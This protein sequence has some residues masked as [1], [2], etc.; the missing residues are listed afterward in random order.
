MY[1]LPPHQN[2]SWMLRTKTDFEEMCLIHRKPKD[3]VFSDILNNTQTN[4][5]YSPNQI[6]GSHLDE[7]LSEALNRCKY[8]RSF[9]LRCDTGDTHDIDALIM[10]SNEDIIANEDKNIGFDLSKDNLQRVNSTCLFG[11]KEP[12][13]RTKRIPIAM[14]NAKALFNDCKTNMTITDCMQ[15]DTRKKLSTIYDN[16]QTI[17]HQAQSG[18]D[19]KIICQLVSQLTKYFRILLGI[20]EENPMLLTLLQLTKK[21]CQYLNIIANKVRLIVNSAFKFFKFLAF[22]IKTRWRSEISEVSLSSGS[23]CLR[24]LANPIMKARKWTS[25]HFGSPDWISNFFMKSISSDISNVDIQTH[26]GGNPIVRRIFQ[27]LF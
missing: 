8:V 15:P 27:I 23:K 21:F 25:N 11:E 24:Y 5:V 6:K 12:D 13:G 14:R 2:I 17:D 16:I 26:R 20:E 18:H 10:L 7:N 9:K 4:G 3:K 22:T 1:Y 19:E